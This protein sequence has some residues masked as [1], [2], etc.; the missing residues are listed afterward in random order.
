MKK[1]LGLIIITLVMISLVGPA[2]AEIYHKSA[3][4][5]AYYTVE[6]KITS[7]EMASNKITVQDNFGLPVRAF[8]SPDQMRS[9]KSGDAVQFIFLKGSRSAKALRPLWQ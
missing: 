7:I 2:C 9:L 3:S 5:G 4:T 1:T 8:L 6:G